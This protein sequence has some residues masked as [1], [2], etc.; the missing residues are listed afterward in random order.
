MEQPNMMPSGMSGQ[1]QG[2]Q[3]A[4][5]NAFNSL[6]ARIIEDMRAQMGQFVNSWQ[7]TFDMRE[8]ANKTL[9]L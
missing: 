2:M 8:R 4:P 5:G 7:A 1:P 9:Q 6:W 3:R